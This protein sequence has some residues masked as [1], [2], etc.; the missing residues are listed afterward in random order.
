MPDLLLWLILTLR[1][2]AGFFFGLSCSEKRIWQLTRVS[3][4]RQLLNGRMP[5]FPTPSNPPPAGR[6]TTT[7]T[8]ACARFGKVLSGWGGDIRHNTGGEEGGGLR[9]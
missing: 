8:P 2:I 1:R 4:A 6:I 5:P 9:I 3:T 7:T